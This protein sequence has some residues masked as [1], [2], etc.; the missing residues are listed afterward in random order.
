VGSLV[1]FAHISVSL[2]LI[3]LLVISLPVEVREQEEVGKGLE[4]VMR[5]SLMVVVR[6]QEAV[7][8]DTGG[9]PWFIITP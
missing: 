7:A 4:D 5:K 6:A 8:E 1:N 3:I 2:A 9:Y